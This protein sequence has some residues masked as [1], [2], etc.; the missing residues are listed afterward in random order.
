MEN[1]VR[2]YL[3]I[4][5]TFAI[6]LLMG[7]CLPIPS[8]AAEHVPV[9]EV[10]VEFRYFIADPI[11]IDNAIPA[12][13]GGYW[14]LAETYTATAGGSNGKKLEMASNTARK[15]SPTLLGN[16]EYTFNEGWVDDFGNSYGT[17]GRLVGKD[18]ID[19]FSDFEGPS[20]TL[21]VY[22]QYTADYRYMFYNNEI[23]H[24]ANG[25]HSESHI[26][27]SKTSYHYT[28]TT[29]ADIPD[30][31][32]FLY[33]DSGDYGVFYPGSELNV[34][35]ENLGEDTTM[36]FIATY[37]YTPS[38]LVQVVYKTSEGIVY[39]T[40]PS[41]QPINI[42]ENAPELENG[43]WL[44]NLCPCVGDI[45]Y[46]EDAE[47]FITTEPVEDEPVI[48]TYI[49]YGV[50][51]GADGL[52]G[53]DGV[54]GIDGKDGIDGINGVDGKD[55]LNGKDGV[56]GKDGLNGKDGVDGV[57][58][59]TGEKGDTGKQGL[60]GE[61][62]YEVAVSEGYD[63][64]VTEWLTSLVGPAGPQGVQGVRGIQGIQGVPGVQGIQG[65][66]GKDGKDGVDG[67]DLTTGTVNLV[68]INEI[69]TIAD[70][71]VPLSRGITLGNNIHWGFVNLV[72]MFLTL[73]T[74][75]IP[76]IFTKK[77]IPNYIKI[78]VSIFSAVSILTFVLTEDILT[79]MYLVD[80]WTWLMGVICIC[81]I[82]LVCA[83]YL[84]LK[85]EEKVN[86]TTEV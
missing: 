3:K 73:F 58:G 29:P 55:G 81:N 68:P 38:S 14:Q 72:F 12:D 63:G 13:G 74:S 21:R 35:N 80:S 24:V 7:V 28:F 59:D 67:K 75:F 65:V 17:S 23:D 10:T 9:Q 18:F 83:Y 62:A 69:E 86:T 84:F 79:P 1:S 51:D 47:P 33:W 71:S 56:D 52:D 25:S 54:D 15:Y 49:V 36:N 32:N 37:E 8:Y 64:T 2:K 20:Q 50:F 60:K 45:V 31:Y 70:D 43:Q 4:F 76:I 27:D 41:D 78:I 42:K 44:F 57:K 39:Q 30:R 22:A 6:I 46:P 19:M 26:V 66:A 40:E 82:I 85:K 5:L 11:N 16:V 77:D 48:T 53:K 34:T 61:S